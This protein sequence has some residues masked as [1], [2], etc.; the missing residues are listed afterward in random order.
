M[1]T[2]GVGGFVRKWKATL[3]IA[4]GRTPTAS[5]SSARWQV[6]L[7]AFRK[8]RRPV[9]ILGCPRSGTTY[10]GELLAA[11]PGVS[12][13]FEPRA[14]K[15]YARLVYEK[16]VSRLQMSC[17]YKGGLRLLLFFAPGKGPRI[18]EKNPVH[19]WVAESLYALFPD[20][21]FVV[22]SRDGRD[23]ALSLLHKPWHLAAS[24]DLNE[25]EPGEYLYGPYPRFYIEPER[26]DEYATTSDLHRCI[27]IW[28]RF[29]EEIVRL[30]GALPAHVQHHL[31]YEDLVLN[32]ETTIRGMLQ[33]L[34]ESD[35]R[36][37]ESVLLASKAAHQKSV[38][39]W[40]RELTENQ[41]SLINH[42][43]GPVLRTLGYT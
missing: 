17:V 20:A 6:R 9:F 10:L 27:W 14:L 41:L 34:R 13:Y 43:A 4:R 32:P 15:Y 39:R 2:L 28:R 25:R 40:M 35:E 42:E 38:N 37:V 21:Q 16:K 31:R 19:T 30:R 18:V 1:R 36:S 12:Y 24:A 33:F 26:A 7:S 23:T 22:I 8:T 3:G 11:L 5:V 29:S